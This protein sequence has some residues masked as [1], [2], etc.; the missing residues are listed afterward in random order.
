MRQPVFTRVFFGYFRMRVKN[1]FCSLCFPLCGKLSP[2]NHEIRNASPGEVFLK[3]ALV[4]CI[5]FYFILIYNSKK[6]RY[7]PVHPQ[8]KDNS[9]KIHKN[10]RK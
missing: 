3:Y 1:H 2:F 9:V 7:F 6:C 10:E 4:I 8:N 5:E